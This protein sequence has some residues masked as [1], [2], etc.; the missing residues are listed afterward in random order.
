VYKA[1]EVNALGR[2]WHPACF[3][4]AQCNKK[5]QPGEAMD[6]EAMPFCQRC[7]SSR[8]GSHSVTNTGIDPEGDRVR[9][10]IDLR[11]TRPDFADP[12]KQKQAS[13]AARSGAAQSVIK[14]GQMTEA[15]LQAERNRNALKNAEKPDSEDEGMDFDDDDDAPP[16]AAA[17][18]GKKT[19]YVPAKKVSVVGGATCLKCGKTVGFAEKIVALGGAWHKGTCFTCHKSPCLHASRLH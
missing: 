9:A 17:L 2:S 5:L 8:W 12:L 3:A 14:H 15:Q 4:C 6:H 19:G 11:T 1:E 7:H 13:P 10:S 18:G 16:S